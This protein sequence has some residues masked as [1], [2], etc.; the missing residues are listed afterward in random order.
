MSHPSWDDLDAFLDTGDFAVMAQ[1]SSETSGQVQTCPII[2][3][4]P[5]MEA[6]LGDYRMN[7]PGPSFTCK[8]VDVA[9]FKKHDRAV[10]EGQRYRLTHDPQPDGTGLSLVRLALVASP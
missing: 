4:A 7:A 6:D 5:Y 9:A 10:I 8:Q 3:D 2:F 1:L